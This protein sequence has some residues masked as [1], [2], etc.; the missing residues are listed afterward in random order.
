MLAGLLDDTNSALES[1]RELTRGV[2]PTQ[3]TRA[4]LVP[5]LRSRLGQVGL[6][7]ILEVDGSVADRRFTPRVEMAVYFCCAEAAP[8]MSDRSSVSLGADETSLR[9]RLRDVEPDQIDLQAIADRVAAVDGSLEESG[10]GLTVCLPI[11]QPASSEEDVARAQAPSS[12]S[13][14]NSALGT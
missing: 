5:A 6:A 12:R 7:S 4:G 13:G 3:L 2:Y 8:A 11:A 1:L 14:P 9:L 10:G